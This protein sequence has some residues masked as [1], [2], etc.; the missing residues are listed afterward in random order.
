MESQNTRNLAVAP[1]IRRHGHAEPCYRSPIIPAKCRLMA[2]HAITSTFRFG[3][4]APR[5]QDR[6]DQ[7]REKGR[8][9]ETAMLTDTVACVHM[10]R[11]GFSAIRLSGQP[12]C[13]KPMLL[14]SSLKESAGKFIGETVHNTILH[15]SWCYERW[16]RNP[17]E[18]KSEGASQHYR[19]RT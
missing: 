17:N 6:A 1:K 18:A 10:V 3:T 11:M 16:P 13:E 4:A 8:V 9:V 5:E 14:F 12:D 15:V 19:R 7:L 2:V